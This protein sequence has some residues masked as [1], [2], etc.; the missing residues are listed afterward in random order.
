MSFHPQKYL[1]DFS[2]VFK[3]DPNFG[4]P[5]AGVT[6]TLLDT[7]GST[8]IQAAA[9]MTAGQSTTFDAASGAS[10]TNPYLINVTSES[11]FVQGDRVLLEN[12]DGQ[13][14]IVQI[15]KVDTG[16]LTAARKL[17]YDYAATDDVTVTT[18]TY[19]ITSTHTATAAKFYTA[20]LNYAS[21]GVNYREV[22]AWH[23]KERIYYNTLKE[24]DLFR[25]FPDL[26]QYRV[27]NQ[28]FQGV[29]D[30]AF[31]HCVSDLEAMSLDIDNMLPGRLEVAQSYKAI[32]IILRRYSMNNPEIF[33][34][35]I[36]YKEEYEK[37][38]NKLTEIT[39]YYDTDEDAATDSD[40]VLVDQWHRADPDSYETY[41]PW[42]QDS[43]VLTP[44]E[45]PDREW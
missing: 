45:L 31:D 18:Y 33:D 30:S 1:K 7:D 8:E 35:L 42:N 22:L 26:D 28:N 2:G 39:S 32:E 44:E 10:E 36:E 38:F 25:M 13:S 20:V 17:Q 11:G 24:D 40:E 29:I 27:L 19:S 3:F 6:V 34:T 15:V 9:S 21:G 37:H 23:V 14:E 5:S 43:D 41:N 12:S 4:K 16:V